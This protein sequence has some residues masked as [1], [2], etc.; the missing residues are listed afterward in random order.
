MAQ[1]AVR[2]TTKTSPRRERTAVNA[3]IINWVELGPY[4]SELC[5]R[6]YY[7]CPTGSLASPRLS[8]VPRRSRPPGGS[9]A[10]RA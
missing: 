1:K 6:V 2:I 9:F 10:G 4:A 5:P 7:I 8:L 3:S